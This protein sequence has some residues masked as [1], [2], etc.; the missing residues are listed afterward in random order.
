MRHQIR[1]KRLILIRQVI[2]PHILHEEIRHQDACNATN[3]RHDERPAFAK[4]VLNGREG[5]G[6]H[7]GAGFANGGGDAVA[8]STHGGSVGFGGEEAEHIAGPE[9][10]EGLHETVEDDKEGH[11]LG[12]FIV[13]AADDEAEDD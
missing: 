10:T 1:P 8:G 7:C 6:A 9:V 13:G 5:F 2:A 3:R 12:N 11:D 4:V